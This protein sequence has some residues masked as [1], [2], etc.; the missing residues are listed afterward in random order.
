[1]KK[2]I[3]VIGIIILIA[4]SRVFAE[5]IPTLYEAKVLS[6]DIN[7]RADSTV[8][9]DK[10][11][12][13]PKGEVVEVVVEKYDWC[14]IRLPKEAPA[15]IRKD[16]VEIIDDQ[17]AKV[18]KDVINVRLSSDESSIILGKAGRDEVVI[19]LSEKQGWYA[20]EPTANSFGW[21]NK[22]FIER[23]AVREAS[24]VVE[25]DKKVEP[26]KKEKRKPVKTIEN[27][28]TEEEIILPAKEEVII[29]GIIQ[30]YGRVFKRVATHKLLTLDEKT[31]LLK[32]NKKSLDDLVYRHVKISG[33]IISAPDQKL[34]IIEVS[35]IE[36]LD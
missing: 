1:M 18:V 35:K 25:K 36:A 34:P 3:L 5:D 2:I 11:T 24:A 20:I 15:Y 12:T 6:D 32:G 7:V 30:S 8:T 19:I 16:L 22:K 13:L 33:T 17:T 23:I 31:Y 21:V 10:I 27:K 26:K 29:E 28:T 14:R 4:A 9:A